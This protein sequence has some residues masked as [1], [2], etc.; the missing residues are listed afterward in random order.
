M[1]CPFNNYGHCNKNCVFWCD[2]HYCCYLAKATKDI[3]EELA[4]IS[5]EIRKAAK[6]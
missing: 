2:K 5:D 4:K 3:P 1:Y 6:K